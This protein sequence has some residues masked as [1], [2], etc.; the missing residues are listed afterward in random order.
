M[1]LFV[2]GH[3]RS[4]TTL[5][6]RLVN[7]HP[8]VNI[9][10]EFGNFWKL[11]VPYPEYARFIFLRWWKKRNASFIFD[12]KNS[13]KGVNMAQNFV[14]VIRYLQEVYR[15]RQELIGVPAIETALKH[16]YPGCTVVGD[17][18]PDY[19]FRLDELTTQPDLCGLFIYRDPRDVASSS[20]KRARTDWKD[21]W[22]E[23]LRDP[24]NIALRWVEF[25]EMVERYPN[26]MFS[27]RYEELVTHPQ[28]VMEQVGCWL[29]LDPGGFHHEIVRTDS[30]GIHSSG[31]TEQEIAGV[32]E[33]AGPAMQRM[34][35]PI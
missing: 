29:D 33:V 7:S 30:I 15:F 28:A 27:V 35:Y 5:L 10:G 12:K 24:R 19:V 26:N 2:T 23:E 20:V 32:I 3:Q 16:L 6:M 8:R 4:G 17:K 14:F 22:P 18:Y 21:S 13:I 11:D 31:L 34:G 9:M 1:A 25:I